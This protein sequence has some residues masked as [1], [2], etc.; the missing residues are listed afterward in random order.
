MAGGVMSS[1]SPAVICLMGPTAAGK[2]DL[3]LFLADNLPCELVSVDSA[4]VYRGMDIGTA[5]PDA[6]TLARYPHHLVDILDPAQAY[7]AALF[8]AD[9]LRL[10]AEISARGR[11]PLL[12]GGTMLY[13]K[14]L[15]DGL[16]PMPQADAGVR[17]R[18]EAMAAAEGWAAVHARLAEVDPES[19]ARIHPND[20]QRIQRAYEV[21]LV[22]GTS[23]SD[24]HRLQA[25]EK[26]RTTARN[27]T[28]LPYTMHY[29]SVA[30][31]ARSILHERIAE[32]FSTMLRLGF[33]DEVSQLH[34]RSDLHVGMPSVRAVGYRQI[35]D[36]LDGKLSLDEAVERGVIA[37]RQLAKR[38]MTWL[39][40]WKSD[41]DWFDSM[42]PKRFAQALKRVE[43][44]TI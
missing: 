11:I 20:P 32:R 18:L 34:A 5:K 41:I 9:V 13:F 6:D 1:Q 22:S 43:Q 19:A 33:V 38:Q 27:G 21:F 23:L 42:D 15:A 31:R 17:H 37:T 40:G 4:L 10:I 39:R 8:R 7:S 3:A 24:W 26:A 44:I 36:H 14:A 30:P 16:A 2:T 12:V 35:W 29:L 28:F 25:A